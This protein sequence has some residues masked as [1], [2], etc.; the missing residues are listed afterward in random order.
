MTSGLTGRVTASRYK[1]GTIYELRRARPHTTQNP[2]SWTTKLNTLFPS[3]RR[4]PLR[5]LPLQIDDLGE[6][7]LV[8]AFLARVVRFARRFDGDTSV[9]DEF[10]PLPAGSDQALFG[11]ALDG[12]DTGQVGAVLGGFLTWTTATGIDTIVL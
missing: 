8:P 7:L 3:L 11:D 6:S 9:V 12:R 4:G 10:E 2:N 5:P 1:A